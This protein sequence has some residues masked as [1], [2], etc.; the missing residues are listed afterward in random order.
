MEVLLAS[1]TNNSIIT[2]SQD[3][4]SL[5]NIP[6]DVAYPRSLREKK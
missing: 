1:N 6:A 4:Y 3:V 2:V 5:Q